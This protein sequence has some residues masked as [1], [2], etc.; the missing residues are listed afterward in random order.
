MNNQNS[1]WEELGLLEGISDPQR[2]H[3]VKQTL[4]GVENLIKGDD[5][6][7][8]FRDTIMPITRRLAERVDWLDLDW[9]VCDYSKW[10]LKL[11][12]PENTSVCFVEP[13]LTVVVDYIRDVL[14]RLPRPTYGD[15]HGHPGCYGCQMCWM[16]DDSITD[17]MYDSNFGPTKEELASYGEEE[18]EFN[19]LGQ[20]SKI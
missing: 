12:I 14:P 9:L 13:E 11:K 10:L 5:Y 6:S 8:L 7:D 17:M 3:F 19:G 18:I 16:N 20:P 2:L 1:N 15:L 4:D